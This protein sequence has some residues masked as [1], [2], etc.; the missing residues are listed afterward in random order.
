MKSTAFGDRAKQ[1]AAWFQEWNRCE[2]T[3]VLY[4]LLTKMSATQARFFSL[5]LEHV[6]KNGQDTQELARM[7]VDANNPGQ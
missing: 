2:Q 4:S 6:L 7:E 1:L 5:V 3:I